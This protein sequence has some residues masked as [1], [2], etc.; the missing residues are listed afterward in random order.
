MPASGD[1]AEQP[2]GAARWRLAV[3]PYALGVGGITAALAA[4]LLTRLTAWPPNEDETLVFFVSRQPVGELLHTVAGERGGA[5]LHFLLAH[6]VLSVWDS[7]SA[8]RLLSAVP[9]ILSLPVVAAVVARLAGRRAA[10]LASLLVAAGWTTLFHGIYARMYGL[11]LLLTALTFLL[12]LRA[13]ERGTWLRWTLW[14]LAMLAAIATQ[15]YGALVLAS[16]GLYVLYLRARTPRALLVPAAAFGLVCLAAIPLWT[17]YTHLA[18]RFDVGAGYGSAFSPGDLTDYLWT[19]LGDF[20]AG[21]TAAEVPIALAALAGLV[22]LARARRDA[23]VLSALVVLVPTAALLVTRSGTSLF[24][25]TRHLIFVLPFVAMTLAVA[26]LSAARLAGA[27]GP[28]VLALATATLV[29]IELAWG[30]ART[31]WLYTGEPAVRTQARDAA[32]RW[33]AET[34]RPDDVLLGYEPTWLDAWKA[35]APYGERFV[36]R[37]DPALQLE[38]LREPG[39][40]LGRGVWV[41]DASDEFYPYKVRLSIPRETPGPGFEA[42]TFGP[43]LVVRTTEPTRTPAR[44]LEQSVQVQKLGR[45]LGIGD[46]IINLDTAEEA[47]RRAQG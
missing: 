31:P 38:T 19:T 18:S 29:S 5:P 2:S 12:L 1:A 4:F 25:E 14:G 23:A 40:P 21:W 24:H 16:Q 6:V 8:L 17:T 41:L 33:L 15:P 32:A 9:V 27:Y 39:T 46:S 13:L 37:A 42:R 35:G 28:A 44:F 43:F 20:F 11:F 7:L 45:R 30:F 3:T 22:L 10:L 26:I 47:L 34:G 36:P